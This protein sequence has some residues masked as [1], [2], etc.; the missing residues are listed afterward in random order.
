MWRSLYIF[1]RDAIVCEGMPEY[2]PD[3][4]TFYKLRHSETDCSLPASV[5]DDV[6]VNYWGMIGF[7]EPLNN[8]TDLF[9]ELTDDEIFSIIVALRE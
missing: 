9:I 7:D 8:D 5:E 1:G 2:L 3:G 4:F 6:I